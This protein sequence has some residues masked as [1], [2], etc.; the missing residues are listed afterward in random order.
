[1]QMQMKHR[2]GIAAAALTVG[3]MGASPAMA[4]RCGHSYPVDAPTTLAKVARACNVSLSALREANTGVDPNYVSPG[5]HLA[6]P[7]EIASATDIPSGSANVDV[8]D[9]SYD[10]PI[11]HYA[12]Y[13]EPADSNPQPSSDPAYAG[14]T[15]VSSTTGPYFVQASALGAPATMRE[16]KS[17][18]YQQLSAA[19][20]RNAGAVYRPSTLVNFAPVRPANPNSVMISTR[21]DMLYGDPLSPLMECAVLRRQENGKIKQVR[22]FKPLPEGRETPAHCAEVTSISAGAPM[23]LNNK[24]EASDFLRSEY[25]GVSQPSIFTVLQGYVSSADS[26]CV[27]LRSDDG[28]VWRVSVPLAPMELLGK[29]ATIWAELTDAKQCG[30]LIMNRAVYAERVN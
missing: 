7:D 29:D 8:A 2:L 14:P 21:A 13:T 30:G 19:R 25:E 3:F 17:L 16:D 28:M 24:L 27:T 12:E 23:L 1:M 5:E 10:T 26:D 11:Y 20:I 22:E 6:I 9:S 4:G 18:S 15:Y